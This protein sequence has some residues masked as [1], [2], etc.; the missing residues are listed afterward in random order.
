MPLPH[1]G[2]V[3]HQK[4]LVS[5]I[6][7]CFYEPPQDAGRPPSH[8]LWRMH[9]LAS[10]SG[11]QSWSI[12]SA[13]MSLMWK[14]SPKYEPRAILS[15]ICKWQEF[16]LLISRV[17][18]YLPAVLIS[19]CAFPGMNEKAGKFSQSPGKL[20]ILSLQWL[21]SPNKNIM[22]KT[23]LGDLNIIS[24]RETTHGAEQS[25]D[26]SRVA[27]FSNP[28]QF[29]SR[30]ILWFISSLEVLIVQLNKV[31]MRQQ[32]FPVWLT[33]LCPEW[34]ENIDMGRGSIRGIYLEL[35]PGA[36]IGGDSCIKL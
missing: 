29:L 21:C 28:K 23:C 35:L 26:I 3:K 32:F 8:L 34:M 11:Q 19:N 14:H 4:R 24:Q 18:R 33:A 30:H 27:S 31:E 20:H 17:N 6:E 10:P 22:S 12:V 36:Q 15:V 1:Q 16:Y 5:Q 13:R 7:I 2:M 9:T 25:E